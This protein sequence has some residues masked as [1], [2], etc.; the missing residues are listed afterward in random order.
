[1]RVLS[2]GVFLACF[3]NCLFGQAVTGT[4]VGT[5]TDSSGAV[6]PNATVLTTETATGVVRRTQTN[7]EGWYTLPYLPP[8][9]YRVEVE[10][11]GFKKFI[12]DNIELRATMSTRV[13][14]QLE[15]GQVTEVVECGLRRRC[16]KLIARRFHAPLR[17]RQ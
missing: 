16:C 8:G 12:R 1:M 13:D 3:T 6:V 4:L 9:T 5:V 10:A 15:P 17:A 11:P 2:L 14:V 7:A